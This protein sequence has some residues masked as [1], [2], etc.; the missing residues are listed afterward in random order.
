MLV[1]TWIY[2]LIIL[3]M[4]CVVSK[5]LILFQFRYDDKK[6]SGCHYHTRALD[7]AI[8]SHKNFGLAKLNI[9]E[10]KSMSMAVLLI[11][12][13]TGAKCSSILFRYSKAHPST[14]YIMD[15]KGLKTPHKTAR[16]E[17]TLTWRS[18]RR[19][20]DMRYS[21]FFTIFVYGCTCA[22]YLAVCGIW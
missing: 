11:D 4:S 8:I 9:L 12:E 7:R 10:S 2:L 20:G 14:R 18:R 21:C 17:V 3:K 1:N 6:H 16:I 5:Q 22:T 19:V 15:R 13:S